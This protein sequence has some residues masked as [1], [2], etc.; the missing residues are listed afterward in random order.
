MA[1]R[2]PTG[3]AGRKQAKLARRGAR[4]TH[5]KQGKGTKQEK[6][7]KRKR[8]AK[9]KEEKARPSVGPRRSRTQAARIYVR[10][11]GE[12]E[13]V[14]LAVRD[15]LYSGSWE[16]MQ[17]DLE[18]RREGRTYVFRLASRIEEDL[19][20]IRKLS[21]FE[22]RHRVNLSEYLEEGR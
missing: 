8:G 13:R 11:L 6:G 18:A 1:R 3:E 7:A 20:A 14:A 9:Q 15:E 2:S 21:A 4:I 5:K 16:D 12:K 19:N 22:R 10:A 17:E